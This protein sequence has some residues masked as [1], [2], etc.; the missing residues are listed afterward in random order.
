MGVGHNSTHQWVG[1]HAGVS[2]N[3]LQI[4]VP[5]K[6]TPDGGTSK[7]AFF[8]GVVGQTY[9]R[10]RWKSKAGCD[11]KDIPHPAIRLEW[12]DLQAGRT[13][14]PKEVCFAPPI[15]LKMIV[16][17][18]SSAI[19]L[20]CDVSLSGFLLYKVFLQVLCDNALWNSACA[21]MIL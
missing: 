3:Q 2:L 14:G 11:L 18:L 20:L 4:R 19:L 17:Y 10:M 5:S 12:A 7:I 21:N 13:D 8:L 1:F 6:N 9:L 16:C 15:V